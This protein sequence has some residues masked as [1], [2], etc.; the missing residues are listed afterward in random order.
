MLLAAQ[1]RPVAS[2]AH[3]LVRGGEGAPDVDVA[4]ARPAA[5]VGGEEE[6]EE[7][8]RGGRSG[9]AR[10]PPISLWSE[11]G[12]RVFCYRH[13]ITINK[14]RKVSMWGFS[15]FFLF[16]TVFGVGGVVC[17]WLVVTHTCGVG[18]SLLS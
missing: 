14:I 12:A 1:L 13:R 3:A 17:V 9:G 7:G 18:P 10:D 8:L 15:A 4:G 2:Q 11:A 6:E 5:P 16:A